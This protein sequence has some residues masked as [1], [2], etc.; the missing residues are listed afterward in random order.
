MQNFRNIH[1]AELRSLSTVVHP[2]RS[3]T[4]RVILLFV[5]VVLGILAS[6][7][8]QIG[9]EYLS[10]TSKPLVLGPVLAIVVRVILSQER[11]REQVVY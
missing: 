10:D 5:I 1:S 7:F 6:W 11:D 2:D 8:W 4:I 9:W 3:A